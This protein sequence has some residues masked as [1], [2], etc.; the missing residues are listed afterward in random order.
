MKSKADRFGVHLLVLSVGILIILFVC[1]AVDLVV[2]SGPVGRVTSIVVGLLFGFA[3]G[4][5][6]GVISEWLCRKLDV[7]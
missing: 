5:N 4:M 3:V 6:I 1:R 2:P 7:E